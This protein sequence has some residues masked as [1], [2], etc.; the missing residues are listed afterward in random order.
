MRLT[1]PAPPAEGPARE[2]I[3]EAALELM[4]RTGVAG[5]SMRQLAARCGLNVATIYHHFPSKA[6]LVRSV[7]EERRYGERLVTDAPPIDAGAPAARRLATL[8]DW[9]W[10]EALTEEAVWGL[11]VGEALRAEPVAV[12]TARSL[13]AALDA[14]FE[15]WF[16]AGFPELVTTPD[17]A[18]R[19][20]R[21]HL[22]ALVVEHLSIGLEAGAPHQRA[23]DL[24]ALLFR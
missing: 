1:A 23:E 22:L 3:L 15:Q 2:R 20:L 19:V 9:L 6:D 12:D 18:A 7:L 13:V 24:A 16:A 21:S 4:S 8:L 10:A 5:T 11:L 14:A 17:V